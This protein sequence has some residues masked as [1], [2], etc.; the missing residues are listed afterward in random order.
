MV[1]G[2]FP[3]RRPFS[4]LIKSTRRPLQVRG[5][6]YSDDEEAPMQSNV[7]LFVFLW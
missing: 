6:H 5:V 7:F 1:A 3:V 2:V 4:F